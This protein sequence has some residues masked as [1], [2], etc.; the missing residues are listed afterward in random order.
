MCRE[1]HEHILA[2]FLTTPGSAWEATLKKTK[3]K[4]DFVNGINMLLMVEKGI[5]GERCHGTD[6]F[7][8]VN[9]KYTKDYD[10]NKESSYFTG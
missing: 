6:W 2:C 4:L 3:V 10:K 8:K 9:R 7:L 1:M 5:R